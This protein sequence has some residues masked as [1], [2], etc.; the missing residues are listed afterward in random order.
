M[1]SAS[2][3]EILKRIKDDNIT[4]VNMQFS[5]M[6]GTPKSVT[7]PTSKLET[8]ID[9][10]LW[11]DGS[12][13]EGFT[14]I[15]ESDMLLVPDLDTYSI[16]PWLSNGEYATARIICDVHMPDG[17]PFYGDPRYILKKTLEEAKQIG[18]IYNT[19]PEL[20]F[21]LFK[22]ENG[23]L[24]TSANQVIEPHDKGQYFDMVMDLGFDVRREMISVLQK[25]GIDVEVSHHEVAPG[26]HEI[27]FRYDNALTTADRAMTLK[28][29]MKAIAAKHGL[30]ATFMPKPVSGIN[31]SGMHV[32]QSLFTL[33][34]ENAFYDASG[35]YKLSKVAYS[36][37]GGQM[38]HVKAMAAILNPTVNSYK[39]LVPGYEAAT[40]ICWAHQNR[41]ALIRIPKYSPGKEKSTRMEIRCPDPSSNPYLAFAVLLKAGLSGIKEGVV[42]P[43]PVEGDV[44]DF[45]EKMLEQKKIDTLPYSLW[46]SLKALQRDPVISSVLGE[47]LLKKYVK[48]KQDEWDGFRTA[49][50]DWETRE[51]LYRI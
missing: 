12:S 31:G 5:D 27:G 40:Y 6:Q 25:M 33:H 3:D 17:T 22:K 32:H 4:L 39:R 41:S 20:E 18:Y 9:S 10:G 7:I 8:A 35:K 36:F 43:L 44:Y 1:V 26:Q 50:T 51:Y 28:T 42:P 34:G 2:K 23:M 47:D 46:D 45:D 48:A 24:K 38:K 29:V 49:V 11:F 16:I 30:H 37:L 13:V 19:G 14:R 15:Q 21:F